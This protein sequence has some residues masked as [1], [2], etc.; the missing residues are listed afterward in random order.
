[1]IGQIDGYYVAAQIRLLRQIDKRAI[2][3]LEGED[4]AR[5]LD[6]FVDPKKCD[7][8]I[9]FGKKNVIDALDLLEDDA[10]QGIAGLADADFDR[11][12]HIEH[13]VENIYLTDQHD[14][15]LT[16]FTSSALDRYLREHADADRVKR[17]FD[18]DA[19][20]LR[21]AVIDSTLPLAFC[22]LVSARDNL[23]LYFKDLRHD[24]FVS[25]NDLSV[26][27]NQLVNE[28][29]LRSNT[30]CTKDQLLRLIAVERKQQHDC[31]QTANGHDVAAFLGIA[32][33]KMIGNKRIHQTWASEVES[34]LRLAFDW[35][36]LV[37]T[38][39]YAML[40]TWEANNSP[41]QIFRIRPI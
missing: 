37:Q 14:L 35:D 12:F 41:Y 31:L 30:R 21:E 3:L 13:P 8:E 2:L 28:I 38:T 32:L 17:L 15:D 22:R 10:F 34:G 25:P 18:S 29:I 16:I 39:M 9:A 33:R 11:V 7:V 26:D 20:K 27:Y 40:R 5:A 4:D 6:R 1:M 23:S 24:D 36:A 19:S